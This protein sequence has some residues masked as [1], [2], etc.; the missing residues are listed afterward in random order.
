VNDGGRSDAVS[1]RSDADA[2]KIRIGISAC[3]LGEHVRYDGGHKRAPCLSGR[4]SRQVEWVPV[5]PEVEAGLGVPREPMRLE[6]PAAK[7]RLLTIT[8]RQDRT[9][10]MTRFSRRRARELEALGLSGFVFK[11]RSP[12]CGLGDAPLY[13]RHGRPVRKTSGLFARAFSKT[14]SPMPMAD[15][16]RLADPRIRANFIERVLVYHRRRR[17]RGRRPRTAADTVHDGPPSNDFS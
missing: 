8:T 9:G 12:S 7:P 4:W 11:A 1:I 17:S 10:T 15:E 2:N 13:D 16:A 6:G 5:C 14:F 3:L